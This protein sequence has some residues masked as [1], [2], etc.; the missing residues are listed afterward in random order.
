M[1]S[2]GRRPH[3]RKP[4][5]E[6]V[7]ASE[8]PIGR[9][10]DGRSLGGGRVTMAV[11]YVGHRPPNRMSTTFDAFLNSAQ[12]AFAFLV[13]DHGFDLVEAI[14]PHEVGSSLTF[15]KLTFRKNG[16]QGSVLSVSLATCP[17][18]LELDLDLSLGWPLTPHNT[19]SVCG[20]CWSSSAASPSIPCV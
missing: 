16:M 10:Q 19:V 14:S 18:R 17:G 3:R 8:P 11:R 12:Y 20:S 5:A 15:H 2:C 9:V 13:A 7:R 1:N 4:M 6:Q